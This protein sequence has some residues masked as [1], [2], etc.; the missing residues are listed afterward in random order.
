MEEL[1]ELEMEPHFDDEDIIRYIPDDG[2]EE[3]E[4]GDFIDDK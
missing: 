3:I 1:L 4:E 2:E